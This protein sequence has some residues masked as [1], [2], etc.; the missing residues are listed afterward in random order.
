MEEPTERPKRDDASAAH[1]SKGVAGS[2]GPI[3]RRLNR[4]ISSRISAHVGGWPVT[5]D[6]WSYISFASVCTGALAFAAHAPR[7]GAALVH[8]G[9]VLDGVDGEVARLQQTASAQGALLDLTLDRASDI[10]LLGG[11]ALGAGRRR[12]DWLLALAAANGIVTAGVVK[13]RVGHEGED[14]AQL[15]QQE[16]VDGSLDTLVRYTGRDGRL[17]AVTLAGLIR[18]PRLALLWLA[19]TSNWRL[20][21]RLGAARALLRRRGDD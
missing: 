4:P 16:A 12:I 1:E 8:A 5:A 7:L 6:Q 9:S 14:V 2:D 11:L 18:Q 13:E 19:A 20:I 17:F 15:Q 10:A 3:S 21:R